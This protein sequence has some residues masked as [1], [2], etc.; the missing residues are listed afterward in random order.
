MASNGEEETVR[1]RLLG[2][3]PWHFRPGFSRCRPLTRCVEVISTAGLALLFGQET[4]MRSLVKRALI[5]LTA[6]RGFSP[7]A[8]C[9]A[10]EPCAQ[11]TIE[12]MGRWHSVLPP[13]S[14][15]DSGGYANLFDDERVRWALDRLG[16]VAG[17]EILELG[18][19]EG[20]HTYMLDRAGAKSIIA[21]EG[22]KSA[23]LKCLVAKE[24]LGIKS[25]HF[26]LGNFLPWL[27]RETREFDLIWASGVLYHSSE[28]LKLLQLIAAHTDKAFIWTHFYPDDFSPRVPYPTPIV[29]I[30]NMPFAGKDIPHFD[31]AYVLS[32]RKSFCGGVYS[33]CS[34]L[35]RGD[36][37]H[38]LSALG[39]S[40][41]EVA[42]EDHVGAQGS[43]F[44]L[45]ARK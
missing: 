20:G 45:L 10:E 23:Y 13:G 37:L 39:F 6:R 44:A 1:D 8:A 21:I 38:V 28:P 40:S 25:A 27:E 29:R 35:R 32:G 43:S 17:A 11:T 41:I 9:V 7:N 34:W 4:D 19:L 42:F 26:L 12:S 33:A 15:L 31:R 14:G 5:A 36:I 3:Q 24:V 18:P 22:L 30:R 16:G 2:R